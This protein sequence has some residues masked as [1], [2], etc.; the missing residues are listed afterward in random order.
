MTDGLPHN[1]FNSQS[2]L[3]ASDGTIYMGTQNG[4]VSFNPLEFGINTSDLPFMINGLI[5]HNT[6]L[7]ST[8]EES[9]YAQ[10]A[11]RVH[12]GPHDN[13]V[14]IVIQLPTITNRMVTDINTF[15]RGCTINGTM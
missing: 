2:Q 12:I 14:T 1:E 6:R 11:E 4:M 10:L 7:D 9:R 13:Q 5:V 15:L 8:Y 3:I